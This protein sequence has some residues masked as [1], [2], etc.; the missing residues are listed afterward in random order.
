MGNKQNWK[1]PTWGRNGWEIASL[2]SKAIGRKPAGGVR[3]GTEAAW[4]SKA[5]G[6]KPNWSIKLKLR[7]MGRSHL[8]AVMD[9]RGQLLGE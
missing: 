5:N 3:V 2:G 7:I 4:E 8:G 1:K 9:G 6:R